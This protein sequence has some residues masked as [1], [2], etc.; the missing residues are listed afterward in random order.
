MA[1]RLNVQSKLH[2]DREDGSN[3]AARFAIGLA[4]MTARPLATQ[5]PPDEEWVVIRYQ[6]PDSKTKLNDILFSWTVWNRKLGG[7]RP[8]TQT[9]STTNASSFGRPSEEEVESF[10]STNERIDELHD[11]RKHLFAPSA[12]KAEQR[13]AAATQAATK[14]S[15]PKKRT[16]ANDEVVFQNAMRTV[17]KRVQGFDLKTESRFPGAVRYT[18]HKREGRSFGYIR[19]RNFRHPNPF[20]FVAEIHRILRQ[21]P[22]NG[23]VLDVRGNGGGLIPNGE[24]LLQLLTPKEIEPAQ[25]QFINTDLTAQLCS[26]PKPVT[27][28]KGE[29]DASFKRR[30]RT[31]QKIRPERRRLASTWGDS[32]RQ[33]NLTG[34]AYSTGK[35]LTPPTLAN[36]IGQAYYGPVVLI[37][38]AQC[39]STTDI[40]AAG[41]P[42]P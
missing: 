26:D 2:A 8:K 38:D 31:F 7:A 4:T 11:A 30:Q 42:G 3:P 28:R 12:V 29:T 13:I 35:P 40:F 25:F 6:T 20:E 1:P 39:Y 15:M 9:I 33:S 14:K 10:S 27:R 16:S 18:T 32:I 22:Q 24:M 41:F 23:L 34:A 37:T 17:R 21:L 19:L 36:H 5:L